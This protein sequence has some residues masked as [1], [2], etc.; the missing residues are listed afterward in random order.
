MAGD[1]FISQ[2]GAKALRV[3]SKLA[4]FSLCLCTLLGSGL[5]E[6]SLEQEGLEQVPG[7]PGLQARVVS[8]SRSERQDIFNPFGVFFSYSCFQTS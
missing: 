4:P 8:V 7:V 2:A 1:V 5:M 3:G 6:S